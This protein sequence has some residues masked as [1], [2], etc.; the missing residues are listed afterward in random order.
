MG[1]ILGA[2]LAVETVT[3]LVLFPTFKRRLIQRKESR[4]RF[5]RSLQK[6]KPTR[7]APRKH[8][9]FL[10]KPS[11]STTP[12]KNNHA[13]A[14][15]QFPVAVNHEVPS[16]NQSKSSPDEIVAALTSYIGLDSRDEAAAIYAEAQ[17]ENKVAQFIVGMALQR[18]GR[19]GAED[20][21]RLSA[22]RDFQ[23]AQNHLQ[24]T[25]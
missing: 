1:T 16:G 12:K 24:E 10:P 8:L 7:P 20:W 4:E 17:K 23:P 25:G 19:S 15:T 2:I 9:Q 21:F 18:S 14:E 22:E 6:P 3:L 11:E 5:L 13:N